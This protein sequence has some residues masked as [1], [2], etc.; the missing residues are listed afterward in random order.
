M[1]NITWKGHKKD[2]LKDKRLKEELKKLE[3][4]FEL[5]R[6][7]IELRMK[8]K[9]TQSELARRAHTSQIVISRLENAHANPSLGLLKRIFRALGKEVRV[10]V[11]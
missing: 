8:K 3:P 2:L 1:K 5:A 11:R 9:L 6:Q 10:A 7:I 4:E